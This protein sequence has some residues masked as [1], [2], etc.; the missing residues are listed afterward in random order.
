MN[1]GKKPT[2]SETETC[3]QL[4][5][6]I[7]AKYM[8]MLGWYINYIDKST[9]NK[10]KRCKQ[11]RQSRL[12]CNKLW[13]LWFSR[14]GLNSGLNGDVWNPK[15]TSKIRVFLGQIKRKRVEI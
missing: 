11:V 5:K 13:S 4:R 10:K 6:K 3:R 7:K 12:N 1:Y 9:E 2:N 15:K 14:W 8:G